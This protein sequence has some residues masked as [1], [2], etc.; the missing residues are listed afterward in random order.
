[1]EPKIVYM[2]IFGPFVAFL[3][4]QLFLLAVSMRKIK[5]NP[6][7]AKRVNRYTTEFREMVNGS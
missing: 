5:R 7:A 6:Q 4:V 3:I 1:M 2:A